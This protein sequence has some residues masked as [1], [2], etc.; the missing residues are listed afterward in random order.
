MGGTS[1]QSAPALSKTGFLRRSLKE[2][3][4]RLAK[5]APKVLCLENLSMFLFFFKRLVKIF[6]TC[7][8]PLSLSIRF[9]LLLDDL[10]MFSEEFVIV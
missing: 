7:L 3:L 10:R 1:N 8:V 9:G 5:T 2:R 6:M 4:K